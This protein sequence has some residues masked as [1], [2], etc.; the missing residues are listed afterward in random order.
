VPCFL[1]NVLGPLAPDTWAKK[2]WIPFEGLMHSKGFK[3][4]AASRSRPVLQRNK[5]NAVPRN[6]L[7]LAKGNLHFRRITEYSNKSRECCQKENEAHGLAILKDTNSSFFLGELI[8]TWRRLQL[9]HSYSFH[10]LSQSGCETLDED[11][12]TLAL[13]QY[14]VSVHH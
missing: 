1:K 12:R 7:A 3:I 2:L 6:N 8:T 4:G 9:P 10:S 5:A 11:T 14:P 13:T